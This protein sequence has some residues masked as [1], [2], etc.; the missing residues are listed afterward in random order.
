MKINLKITALF[1]LLIMLSFEKTYAQDLEAVKAQLK[2]MNAVFDSSYF[3]TFKVNYSYHS[4]DSASAV[5]DSSQRTAT[6]KV[7]GR[8]FFY[9]FGDVEYMQND[10]MA[11]TVSNKD[12]MIILSRSKVAAPS[13]ALSLS[14]LTDTAINA[15]SNYYN[16]TNTV[17][18][19]SSTGSIYFIA[20]PNSNV[21]YQQIIVTYSLANSTLSSISLNYFAPG[22]IPVRD[23]T[24]MPT[25]DI[26]RALLKNDMLITFSDYNYEQPDNTFFKREHYFYYDR[27]Q[28]AYITTGKF[29]DYHLYTNGIPEN[30]QQ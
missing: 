5:Q 7:K 17:D 22:N 3:L 2:K 9:N 19:A 10:S 16:I 18:S 15:Y 1:T 26:K 13:Q 8:N 12:K 14:A 21:P 24:G 20:L 27:M 23:S 29:K 4:Y 6:Y 25:G 11:F 30:K 28:R